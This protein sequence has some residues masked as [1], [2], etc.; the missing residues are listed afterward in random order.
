[1][2]PSDV[3]GLTYLENDYLQLH[4][5]FIPLSSSHTQSGDSTNSDAGRPT[6]ESQGKTLSPSGEQ[7]KEDDENDN[8]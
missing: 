4:D 2:S 3:A 6:N 5:K 7:T 8:R 1:M